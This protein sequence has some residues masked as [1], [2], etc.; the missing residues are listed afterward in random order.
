M[1]AGIRSYRDLIV[2]QKDMDLVSACYAVTK[3][4]PATELFGLSDQIRRSAV[5]MVANIAEGHGRTG[6]G[7]FLYHLS[8]AR[9]SLRELETLL[10]ASQRRGFGKS[11]THVVLAAAADE[12]ARMLFALG[13]RVAASNAKGVPVS[14]ALRPAT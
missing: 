1:A 13:T 4:F 14:S 8:V 3:A 7:Q 12:I 9:G 6:P 2:W 10:L 11:E 5:S